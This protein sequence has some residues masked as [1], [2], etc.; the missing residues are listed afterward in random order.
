M[1]QNVTVEE[2]VGGKRL[3]SDEN[4]HLYRSLELIVRD[5]C[6][7]RTVWHDNKRIDIPA[8]GI[9]SEYALRTPILIYDLPELVEKVPTAF[10]DGF[11]VFFSANLL[12]ELIALRE[13]GK[14]DCEFVLSHELEHIRLLHTS[15]MKDVDRV[16][17]NIAQDIHINIDLLTNITACREFFDANSK[18]TYAHRLDPVVF[19]ESYKKTCETYSGDVIKSGCGTAFS[20]R[21]KWQDKS[22]EQIALALEAERPPKIDATAEEVM[23]AAAKAINDANKA[24]GGTNSD[25]QDLADTLERIADQKHNKSDLQKVVSTAQKAANSTEIKEAD[26]KHSLADD[27][28]PS[29]LEDLKPSHRIAVAASVVEQMLN[30]GKKKG[31]GQP[32]QGQPGQGQPGQGISD[33][34]EAT[35]DGAKIGR[36]GMGDIDQHYI[37]PEDLS[38]ILERA[39][40]QNLSKALGYDT[41]EKIQKMSEDASS[42]VNNAIRKAAEDSRKSGGSYPGQHMVDSALKDLSVRHYRPVLVLEKLK[43]VISQCAGKRKTSYDIMTPSM[44]SCATPSDM[45]FSSGDMPYLGSQRPVKPKKNLIV[46]VVDTSGSTSGILDSLVG[47]AIGLARQT[48]KNETAPEII[49]ISADTIVR[50]KP[51]L[52]NEGNLAKLREKGVGV[53]GFGG[54]DFLAP[55]IGVSKM[56]EKGGV[57]HGRKIDHVF[58][59]TDGECWLPPK[60]KLPEKLPPVLFVV[61]ESHYRSSFDQEVKKSGWCDA[62]FFGDQEVKVAPGRRAGMK[63]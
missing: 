24:A 37:P 5:F 49:F 18:A 48:R 56:T 62:V 30:P 39:N 2:A 3:L 61:P 60:N 47:E 17:A 46:A 4:Q 54:T 45:G 6:E 43:N 44:V 31:Q 20:D 14:V 11:R 63:S 12:K 16:T 10:T 58:Y 7:I 26:E 22:S 38:D 27:A 36:G 29:K 25:L 23:R 59:F 21:Q 15:R 19:S 52:I 40:A 13:A 32:G 1:S 9:S 57:F 8:Y 53:A 33:R 35:K 42:N 34:I 55:L 50:G 51:M 41:P 28:I